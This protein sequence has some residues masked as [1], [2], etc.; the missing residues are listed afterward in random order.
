MAI[1]SKITFLFKTKS[2]EKNQTSNGIDI[3]TF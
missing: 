1:H 2:L 3:G